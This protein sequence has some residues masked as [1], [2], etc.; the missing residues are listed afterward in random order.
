MKKLPFVSIPLVTLLLLP[1]LVWGGD[2]MAPAKHWKEIFILKSLALKESD[3]KLRQLLIQRYNEIANEMKLVI[4]LKYVAEPHP[5]YD[6][7]LVDVS[8]RI[9]RT[10]LEFEDARERGTLL[11]DVLGQVKEL[12]QKFEIL[13]KALK[14]NRTKVQLSRFRSLRLE[15]EYHL[16]KAEKR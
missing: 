4:A 6:E 8:R 15:V 5:W 3:D 9:F 1:L 7:G 2:P 16:A 14:D 11:A 10:A 13:D 12:E